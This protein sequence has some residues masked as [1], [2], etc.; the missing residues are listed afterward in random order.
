VE[1]VNLQNNPWLQELPDP[2]TRIVWDNYICIP[3]KWDGRSKFVYLNNL[4]NDGDLAEINM[5]SDSEKMPIV[6]Q[7]GLL[8]NTVAVALGFGREVS[9]KAGTGVG[10]NMFRYLK[11]DSDGNVQYYLGSVNV[12]GKAGKDNHFASVQHH[13]TLGVKGLDETT[14]EIINVDEKAVMTLGTGFQG[15]LTNRSILRAATLSTLGESVDHLIHERE[16]H[17]KLNS[18]GL[19][20]GH[21][22]AYKAGHHWGL[23]V[24]LSSCIGC[25]ACQVACTAE[26]NVPVVG[27]K[28]VSRHHEMTWLR[29]DRYYYGDVENPQVFLSAD[30]VPALR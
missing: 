23:A 18:Y 15:G 13:H 20:P 9:G 11:R 12:S 22:E 25:G 28:E 17:Q 30:D 2:I 8:Q 29:I 21:D 1:R 27:K 24:D 3:V 6:R 5:G 14:N 26:N 16:H 19:Y 7:F 4:N 10:K